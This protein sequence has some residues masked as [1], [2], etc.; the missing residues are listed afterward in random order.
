MAT[1]TS[2]APLLYVRTTLL[3]VAYETHGPID[4]EPVILL[5]GFPTTHGA[6]MT[7]RRCWLNVVIGYWSRIYAVMARRDLST[8]K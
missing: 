3:D 5:H 2:P 6:T 4:G 7:S 1:V 8:R